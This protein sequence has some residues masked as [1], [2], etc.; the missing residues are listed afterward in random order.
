[1]SSP[2]SHSEGIG[3]SFARGYN[4][5]GNDVAMFVLL[6]ESAPWFAWPRNNGAS[7][8]VLLTGMI[9]FQ[10]SLAVNSLLF[11]SFTKS[12]GTWVMAMPFSTAVWIFLKG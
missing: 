12:L 7:V 6:M 4:S 11:F 3:T 9:N 10:M 1:M 8:Q 5:L 2:K